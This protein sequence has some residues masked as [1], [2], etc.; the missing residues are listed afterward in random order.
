MKKSKRK[1]S[2]K[3][4]EELLKKAEYIISLE[5]SYKDINYITFINY[6]KFIFTNE[7]NQTTL[8]LPINK[9]DKESF[10]YLKNYVNLTYELLEQDKKENLKLFEKEVSQ[11]KP[12][13]QL[14]NYIQSLENFAK[15][16][17][18]GTFT[19]QDIRESFYK[20][21]NFIFLGY[22]KS[23]GKKIGNFFNLYFYYF[24]YIIPSIH[25]FKFVLYY[26]ILQISELLKGLEYSKEFCPDLNNNNCLYLIKS[27]FE[28]VAKEDLEVLS[29]YTLLIFKYKFIFKN[30]K[31]E[32]DKKIIEMSI[33][34]TIAVVRQKTLKN[35]IIIQY[36]YH[37]FII[38]LENNIEMEKNNKI[39]NQIIT[40]NENNNDINTTKAIQINNNK[41]NTN[42]PQN[43]IKNEIID[44]NDKNINLINISEASDNKTNKNEMKDNNQSHEQKKKSNIDDNSEEKESIKK[45]VKDLLNSKIQK[46]I[47]EIE[48]HDY[49][50]S[51]NDD[52]AR[53]SA[54][55]HN[56]NSNHL[57]PNG[58]SNSDGKS[59]NFNGNGEK[60]DNNNNLVPYLSSYSPDMQKLIKE[61]YDKM[62]QKYKEIKEE[63]QQ[64][65]N[66]MELQNKEMERQNKAMKL[67]YKETELQNKAME[68]QNKE[69][70]QQIEEHSKKINDIKN[71]LEDVLGVLGAIQMRD[72]SKNVLRPY[73]GLLDKT[74]LDNLE[75]DK[76]K[77]WEII[78]KK[79]EDYFLKNYK[80][81]PKC[82]IFLEIVE[83]CLEN[84]NKGNYDAHHVNS[85]YYESQLCKWIENNKMMHFSLDKLYFLL[86]IN[87]P[88]NSI[89][90]A[91]DILDQFYEDNMELKFFK[92]RTFEDYFKPKNS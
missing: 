82:K 35:K 55:P 51:T 67:Q 11:I 53:E 80:N 71:K 25:S 20:E 39:F 79:I 74:E 36:M 65:Y 29:V 66:K 42:K 56:S 92:G 57:G 91:Y 64:R 59:T 28:K 4:E 24:E 73:I 9:R 8:S 76:K 70:K 33:E 58:K 62:E 45:M 50:A 47:N 6:I 26:Y 34:Q 37:Y 68:L 41:E 2:K 60:K 23:S 21:V 63:I 90:E 87:I 38:Y 78:A 32:I 43:V 75:K 31:D 85:E 22:L 10:D 16:K 77:K 81:S 13:N 86:K 44:E 17:N 61:I 83:K 3:E 15:K 5:S 52:G 48:V 54:N 84:I 19:I 12:E 72:R 30:I 46:N 27:F 7:F 14:Y 49:D 89:L 88:D 1:I 18:L 69:L 40:N